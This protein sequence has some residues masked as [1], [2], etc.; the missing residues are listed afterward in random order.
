[1][2][3]FRTV[4]II[5]GSLFIVVIL[6]LVSFSLFSAEQ[7][8][9]T[10]LLEWDVYWEYESQEVES[11]P[12]QKVKW[13][14][15]SLNEAIPKK[16]ENVSSAWFR[17]SIPHVIWSQPGVLLNKIYGTEV[18]VLNEESQL[19]YQ[20]DKAYSNLIHQIL[21][22]IQPIE[23]EQ[24]IYIHIKTPD[25]RIGLHSFITI[26]EFQSL[27][28]SHARNGLLDLAF[29][30]A[31]IFMAIV[32]L[33]CGLFLRNVHVSSWLSLDMVVIS[34]GVLLICY[35]PYT[36]LHFPELREILFVAFDIA[37]MTA[38]PCMS[39]Y[40]EK[41]LGLSSTS[42]IGKF[43]RFQMVYSVFMFIL[44]I[45]YMNIS[46]DLY[47][48]YYFFTATMLGITVIIQLVLLIFYSVKYALQK[49]VEAILFTCGFTLFALLL[50]GELIWYYLMSSHYQMWLWKWGVLGF[51]LAM[52][53]ILGRT[54]AQNHE[55]ISRYSKDLE[56]YNNELQHYE[57]LELISELA[58]TV[59][60]EVRNPLQVTRGFIQ[61]IS[62]NAVIK[63]KD[64]INFALIELDR[65][66]AIITDFLTFAKPE[67]NDMKELKLIE[68]LDHIEG[69]LFPLANQ[70]GA[71]IVVDVPDNIRI[72]G[73]SSKF[74]QALVNLVKNSIE[75][76][77]DT[78][79][80]R[81]WA[82]V[83]EGK[84][85]I[86]IRDNGIG[87]SEEELVRLG[88][89]YYTNKQAGTGL[90]LLVTFR[91]IQGMNGTIEFNSFKGTGTEVILTFPIVI[92]EREGEA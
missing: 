77:E 66:S 13:E 61:L 78:G 68:E 57:K 22:P 21:I 37:L 41:M 88:E 19:L 17:V 31:L 86:H 28:T 42:V 12:S 90:G 24:F 48:I 34:I 30:F 25:D 65:A 51:I 45:C 46:A 11:I 49:N 73:N 69:I 8:K 52:V 71:I 26:G 32:L 89:P 55:R 63:E 82:Y 87:M 39:F 1:M 2:R 85:N 54:I 91:I 10:R 59:A 50:L 18:K 70:H 16:P 64:Y 33:L 62:T 20:S 53:L 84:V 36:T 58:A 56:M 81:I 60:H 76:L 29:G 14:N 67:M 9:G 43:R 6:F 74:K 38:L 3:I 80:I 47:P 72:Y 7:S 27:F 92:T 23:Q 75:S 4:P 79:E 83:S 40:F 35:S 5:A 44:L 15:I